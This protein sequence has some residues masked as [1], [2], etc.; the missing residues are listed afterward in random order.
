M[1]R[2][3]PGPPIELGLSA[4][5][6]TK[7]R[8]VDG[9]F[10]VS[11]ADAERIYSFDGERFSLRASL[12]T[13]E[14]AMSGEIAVHAADWQ[15]DAWPM[16][17]AGTTRCVGE[18]L[19]MSYNIELKLETLAMAD[20]ETALG[21]RAELSAR[22]EGE[23]R[24]VSLYDVVVLRGAGQLVARWPLEEPRTL[25]EEQK[26]V[27]RSGV[28]STS[29][30]KLG[31]HWY[32]LA[33]YEVKD[34]RSM[35]DTSVH[36]L[37][38]LEHRK[39]SLLRTDRALLLRNGE[40]FWC[41]NAEGRKLFVRRWG[42]DD[43]GQASTLD[44]LSAALPVADYDGARWLSAVALG[45]G[46]LALVSG[47]GHW[48]GVLSRAGAWVQAPQG[49][50]LAVELQAV[51]TKRAFLSEQSAGEARFQELKASGLDEAAFSLPAGSDCSWQLL[52][53]AGKLWG[54][55]RCQA[56]PKFSLHRLDLSAPGR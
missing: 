16:A 12:P 42:V 53:G 47:I 15:N 17:I 20:D 4:E 6:L 44:T 56:E 37:H 49:S 52:E 25:L 34:L 48:Y 8:W 40:E 35:A 2:V 24:R 46:E 11:E 33:M 9:A 29:L 14:A 19:M 36:V 39:N 43:G 51:G 13:S 54:L 1:L 50:E 21:I 3:D 26:L 30:H 41:L 5:S 32:A 10:V 38:A 27:L 31:G 55:Q 7:A 22:A 28:S 45:K 23:S 18:C